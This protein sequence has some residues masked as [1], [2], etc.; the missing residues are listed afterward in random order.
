MDN[1]MV[2][3]LIVGIIG[4]IITEY[5]THKQCTKKDKKWHKWKLR[6]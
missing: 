1:I 5:L 4:M 3:M 2:I 6:F